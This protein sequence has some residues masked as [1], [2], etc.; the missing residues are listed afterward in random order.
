MQRHT[1]VS[2]EEAPDAAAPV[3]ES[4]DAE[5]ADA[6]LESLISSDPSISA[7]TAARQFIGD[8]L[9]GRIVKTEK[10]DCIIN[11]TSRGKLPLGANKK[12]S[13]K[14]EAIARVPEVLTNGKAGDFEDLY[15][16]RD[17]AITGFYP[18]EK[19]IEIPA[20]KLKAK[21]VIKVGKREND[22]PR[23]VYD[24]NAKAVVLDGVKEKADAPPRV[25]AHE[26][27]RNM[28]ST[29]TFN[30]IVG[31]KT[32]RQEDTTPEL[33][34]ILDAIADDGLNLEILAVWDA[35][36]NLIPELADDYVEGEV[37]PQ[38]EAPAPADTTW[39]ARAGSFSFCAL[40]TLGNL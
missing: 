23:L 4:W 31:R 8:Y 16:E 38:D 9:Q 7:V 30:S 29:T 20:R 15:K 5:K 2:Q 19:V 22:V 33:D 40:R 14:L 36:G 37:T 17:D 18:F 39:S 10:G 13:I 11:N 6:L 28:D 12:D 21:V 32:P 35:D 25:A 3:I 27:Q 34:V 24:L 1:R 26:E